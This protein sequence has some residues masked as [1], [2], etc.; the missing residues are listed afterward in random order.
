MSQTA[1]QPCEQQDEQNAVMF[2]DRISYGGWPI[3]V[4]H[5]RGIYSGPEGPFDC[6]PHVPIYSIPYRS[7]YSVNVENLMMAGRHVSV[8]HIAL[9]T[10]RVEGTLA[11]LGQAAGTAAHLA[12]KEGVEPRHVNVET[13]QRKLLRQG[14]VL[15]YFKD[16]DRADPAYAALQY[17]GTKGFFK[18]Y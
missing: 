18:D 15:T 16:I 2:P 7:L 10:V 1:C 11:T 9:G 3:D 6:D 13:L 5:P 17:F 4:H 12:L 14:Q 8:T